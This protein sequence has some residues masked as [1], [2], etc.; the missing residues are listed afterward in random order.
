MKFFKEPYQARKSL[1]VNKVPSN[2]RNFSSC[3]VDIIFSTA[4]NLEHNIVLK[5]L[6]YG[7]FFLQI[8]TQFYYWEMQNWQTHVFITVCTV[9][10]GFKSKNI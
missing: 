2:P 6:T 7:A 3:I 1:K 8:A 9:W 4:T 5:A 10:Q